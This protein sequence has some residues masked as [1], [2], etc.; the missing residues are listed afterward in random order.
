MRDAIKAYLERESTTDKALKEAYSEKKLDGCMSYIMKQA[1]KKLS[2]C[3]GAIADATVYGWARHFIIDGD[4][5]PAEDMEAQK[6]MPER[7]E[8]IDKM[9]KP[10]PGQ[11]DLFGGLV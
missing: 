8:R 10:V 4:T 3:N 9:F 2:G 5:E 7:K 1:R 6:T 11:L